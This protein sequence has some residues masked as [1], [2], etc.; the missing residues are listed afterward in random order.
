MRKREKKCVFSK[1]D[2]H[3]RSNN[4]FWSVWWLTKVTHI[5]WEMVST[6]HVV[7][8]D[9][10]VGN[11]DAVLDVSA[12]LNGCWAAACEASLDRTSSFLLRYISRSIRPSWYSLSSWAFH[13]ERRRRCCCICSMRS[14]W[15]AILTSLLLRGE[16][17]N[18]FREDRWQSSHTEHTAETFIQHYRLF[19]SSSMSAISAIALSISSLP[20]CF[21]L[22]MSTAG[23]EGDKE[24]HRWKSKKVC[25]PMQWRVVRGGTV[26]TNLKS[27]LKKKNTQSIGVKLWPTARQ[28]KLVTTVELARCYH[29]C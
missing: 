24:T 5:C 15:C 26:L 25:F 21:F 8:A 20:I 3:V 12:R 13:S 22:F 16:D 27:C 28:Y 14:A 19:S 17:D 9:G 18:A 11:K 10:Y 1:Q 2:R 7:K 6:I 23:W 4:N 29:I